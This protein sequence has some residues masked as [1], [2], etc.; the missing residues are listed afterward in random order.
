MT[1]DTLQ[2][3]S[4]RTQ[5]PLRRLTSDRLIGGVAAGLAQHFD[6]DAAVVRLGFVLLT[7]LGG[8][9]VPLYV[10]AW[11]LIPEEGSNQSVLSEL[12]SSTRPA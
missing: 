10:A 5:V 1:T 7:I 9:G 8:F 6:L 12:I 2:S 4:S 3:Q 11:L